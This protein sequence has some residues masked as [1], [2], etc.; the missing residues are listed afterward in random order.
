MVGLAKHLPVSPDPKETVTVIHPGLLNQ[1]VED[2]EEGIGR[3]D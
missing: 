2:F 1:M 3:R